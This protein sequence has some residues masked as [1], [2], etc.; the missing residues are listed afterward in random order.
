MYK[1]AVIENPNDL[2][3]VSLANNKLIHCE[4]ALKIMT[5]YSCDKQIKTVDM[6]GAALFSPKIFFDVTELPHL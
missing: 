2:I 1:K 5:S 4:T 6:R 3:E